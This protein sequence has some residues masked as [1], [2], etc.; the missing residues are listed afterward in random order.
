ML[1]SMKHATSQQDVLRRLLQTD[2]EAQERAKR[3]HERAQQILAAATASA[4]QLTGEARAAA[5]S[6]AAELIQTAR[7]ESQAAAEK[8]AADTQ[9]QIVVMQQRG[10]DHLQAAATLVVDWV[11]GKER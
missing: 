7:T 10:R 3:A 8:L 6:T 2:A 11:T 9:A 5:E 1:A 4:D